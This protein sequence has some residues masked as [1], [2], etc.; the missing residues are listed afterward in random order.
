V[1][2]L[3]AIV[4]GPYVPCSMTS[5]SLDL[6]VLL[7]LLE[8][9][10]MQ[11]GEMVWRRGDEA[12]SMF[13]VHAGKLE[14]LLPKGSSGANGAVSESSSD[15]GAPQEPPIESVPYAQGALVLEVLIPGSIF[16]YLHA[17]ATPPQP[18]FTDVVCVSQWAVV[19]ELPLS[20][21]PQMHL[22]HPKLA[23][24]IMQCVQHR[25]STE[26]NNMTQHQL[27]NDDHWV[28]TLD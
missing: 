22:S 13:I 1:R 28:V 27:H 10:R 12:L 23:L 21:L 24:G 2:D 4:F 3:I 6:D 14:I 26:Y 15:R 7:P 25:C 5:I 8:P 20:L 9:R 19:H 18:R 16:G 17:M 11:C